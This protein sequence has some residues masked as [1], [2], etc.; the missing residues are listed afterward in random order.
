MRSRLNHPSK[1][2]R[3]K[4]SQQHPLPPLDLKETKRPAM[5]SSRPNETRS[6]RP[7]VTT[8]DKMIGIM[9]I[10]MDLQDQAPTTTASR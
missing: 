5:T 6:S 1:F 2:P 4:I 9:V 10:A 3:L 8:A 7:S